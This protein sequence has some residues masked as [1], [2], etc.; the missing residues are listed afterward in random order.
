MIANT[1]SRLFNYVRH[2]VGVATM[3][4]SPE[5]LQLNSRHLPWYV[6]SA[7]LVSMFVR[8]RVAGAGLAIAH[9]AC[10]IG[11]AWL[12]VFVVLRFHNRSPRFPQTVATILLISCVADLIFILARTAAVPVVSSVVVTLVFFGQIS[13]F[14]Y[15]IRCAVE[16]WGAA[17]LTLCAYV[18]VT[19]NTYQLLAHFR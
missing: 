2:A 5:A 4:R 3:R 18:L 19:A 7:F 11:F 1:P 9:A 16:K 10:E 13:G 12:A 8:V 6:L 17:V 15:A 14:L